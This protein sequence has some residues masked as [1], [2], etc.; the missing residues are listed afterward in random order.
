M[1]VTTNKVVNL[2]YYKTCPPKCNGDPESY[3]VGNIRRSFRKVL[4]TPCVEEEAELWKQ[5]WGKGNSEGHNK[6]RIKC[7]WEKSVPWHRAAAKHWPLRSRGN[8]VGSRW[9][10]PHTKHNN[11][12][13]ILAAPLGCE[14]TKEGL[15]HRMPISAASCHQV[16]AHCVKGVHGIA[17][18]D[19]IAY[20]LTKE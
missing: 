15:S 7:Q 19:C 14:W 18:V 9:P 5:K 1:Y 10:C 12:Q 13:L 3:S 6:E 11:Q 8:F 20:A 17:E 4:F 16:S 2:R